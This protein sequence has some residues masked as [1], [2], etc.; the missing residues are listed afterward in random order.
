MFETKESVPGSLTVFKP[1]D[2][3]PSKMTFE[4]EL[5]S[6]EA[7][8]VITGFIIQYGTEDEDGLFRADE[9]RE[10]EPEDRQGTIEGTWEQNIDIFFLFNEP[11]SAYF[12]INLF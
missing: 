5:S 11:E 1:I 7:N 10:F 12:R 3:Q 2:I 8:G 9:S 4:W 6:L